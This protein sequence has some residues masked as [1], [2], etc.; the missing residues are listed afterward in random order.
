AKLNSLL[1]V[2]YRD[3]EVIAD[4][5]LRLLLGDLPRS[6]VRRLRLP[7]R[8]E[9]AVDQLAERAGKRMDDLYAVTGGNPFFVTE[10]LASQDQGVPVSVSDAVLSRLARLTP[11]ARGVVELISVVPAKTEMWLLNETIKPTTALLEEC[12]DAGILLLHTEWICFRHE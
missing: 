2:T 8:S 9:D 3:D 10:A 5:P 7:P 4:H 11:G 12:A 6:C 1:V